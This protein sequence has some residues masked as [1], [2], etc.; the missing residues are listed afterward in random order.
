MKGVLRLTKGNLS[1]GSCRERAKHRARLFR[2]RWLF[3]NATVLAGSQKV[4]A[5]PL[6][7]MVKERQ[8][9]FAFQIRDGEYEK[10]A[11]RD[12]EVTGDFVTFSNASEEDR[13]TGGAYYLGE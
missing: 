1:T 11:L 4:Y 6:D 9:Y 5:L 12:A 7:A 3:V 2:L 13:V 10:T 8:T